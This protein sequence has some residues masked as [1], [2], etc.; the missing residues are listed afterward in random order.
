MLLLHL[1]LYGCLLLRRHLLCSPQ[2]QLLC[3]QP[4]PACTALQGSDDASIAD[5]AVGL[6]K[7]IRCKLVQCLS[8]AVL[9]VHEGYEWPRRD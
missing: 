8:S 6:K 5:V 9:L 7:K 1:L 4:A 2:Q 3:L